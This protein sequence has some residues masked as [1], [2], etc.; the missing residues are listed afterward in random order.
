MCRHCTEVR[1]WHFGKLLLQVLKL[2]ATGKT[3]SE[4]AEDLKLSVATIST[5]RAR[6]LEKMQLKNNTELTLY[7][8]NNGLV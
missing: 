1:G 3:V 8:I 5:Y 6:L 7:A 4:I 2:L